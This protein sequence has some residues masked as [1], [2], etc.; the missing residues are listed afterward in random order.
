MSDETDTPHPPELSEYTIRA[1]IDEIFRRC[2]FGCVALHL[3]HESPGTPS[4]CI[5][6]KCE[7]NPFAFLGVM[8]TATVAVHDLVTNRTAESDDE[9][10]PI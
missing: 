9:K 1:L 5:L 4:I 2:D 7:S 3:M 8:H 10:R 6:T